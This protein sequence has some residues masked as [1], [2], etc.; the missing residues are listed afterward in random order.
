MY[1]NNCTLIFHNF[2]LVQHPGTQIVA[3]EVLTCIQGCFLF[4]T[5]SC[6]AINTP[7]TR[8]HTCTALYIHVFTVYIYIG[9]IIVHFIAN[10]TFRI[11][12][13]IIQYFFSFRNISHSNLHILGSAVHDVILYCNHN[14]ILKLTMKF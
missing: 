2:L 7:S 14:C 12:C 11:Y 9:Y 8:P 10:T 5:Y 13:I 3:V 1:R 4:D 6:M